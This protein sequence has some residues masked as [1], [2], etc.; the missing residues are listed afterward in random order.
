MRPV[1]YNDNQRVPA[2]RFSGRRATAISIF[3]CHV[4]L[5]ARREQQPMCSKTSRRYADSWPFMA[6][7]A[8]IRIAA[9]TMAM[10]AWPRRAGYRCRARWR[11]EKN[12][13]TGAKLPW[14][15]RCR[16]RPAPR[17]R[18]GARA[19]PVARREPPCRFPPGRDKGQPGQPG[20]RIAVSMR[21]ACLNQSGPRPVSPKRCK[22]MPR[23]Q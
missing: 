5:T 12:R 11:A 15:V 21:A 17:S 2:P 16:H 1:L 7:I 9:L 19:A 6:S 3:T 20:F 14:A 8:G 4:E 18:I 22:A 10:P 23:R 13:R